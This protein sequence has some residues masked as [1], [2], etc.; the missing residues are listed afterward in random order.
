MRGFESSVGLSQSRFQGPGKDDFKQQALKK[1][2]L[3]EVKEALAAERLQCKPIHGHDIPLI[4]L[5]SKTREKVGLGGAEIVEVENLDNVATYIENE[6]MQNNKLK[7]EASILDM[8]LPT[9]LKAPTMTFIETE[10]ISDDVFSS[11]ST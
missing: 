11:K 1:G 8:L 9:Q 7:D 6:D 3:N 4:Q 2:L 10:E 5:Q